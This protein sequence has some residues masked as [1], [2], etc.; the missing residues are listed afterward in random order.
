VGEQRVVLEDDPDLP[1]VRWRKC[2]ILIPEENAPGAGLHKAAEDTEKGGFA[3]AG[4]SKNRY[5]LAGADVE[6]YVVESSKISVGLRRRFNRDTYTLRFR[7]GSSYSIF[8]SFSEK[9]KF[10]YCVL[11]PSLSHLV[12]KT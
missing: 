1:L 10:F 5:E 4:W 3:G 7:H 9:A 2:N 11:P 8:I 6:A 12:V